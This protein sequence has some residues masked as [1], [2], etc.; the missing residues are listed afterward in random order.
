MDEVFEKPDI[1]NKIEAPEVAPEAAPEAEVAPK[2]KKKYKPMSDERKATLRAQLAKGRATAR[3]NRIKKKKAA[4][5][6]AA[7]A[8]ITEADGDSPRKAPVKKEPK[9]EPVE[10]PITQKIIN[11]EPSKPIPIPPKPNPTPLPYQRAIKTSRRL[12]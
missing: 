7:R 11:P 12:W 3:A 9:P 2:K 10:A 8:L 6:K 1:E 4:E 5:L